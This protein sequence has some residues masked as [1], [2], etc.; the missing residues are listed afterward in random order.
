[1]SSTREHAVTAHPPAHTPL[2][3]H[4]PY[5]SVQRSAEFQELRRRYRGF[6]FPVTAG[7]LLSYFLY[8]VLAAYTP[9]F[10][11]Q[12]AVGNVTVGLL[13]GLLQFAM[14]FGVTTAYVRYADRVLDPLSAR[15]RQRME[16]GGA[17]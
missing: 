6:V 1:M 17:R 16:A 14:T 10:M 3:G 13:L 5:T 4:D 12:K 8:V 2:D 15:I 9:G 11:G 7:S